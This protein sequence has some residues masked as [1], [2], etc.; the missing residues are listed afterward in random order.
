MGKNYK[1]SSE[2]P[3]PIPATALREKFLPAFNHQCSADNFSAPCIRFRT[4]FKSPQRI[5]GPL[6]GIWANSEFSEPP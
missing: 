5:G 4:G 2:N 3:E 6:R 1:G